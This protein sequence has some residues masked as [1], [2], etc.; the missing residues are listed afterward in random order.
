MVVGGVSHGRAER[1]I[2]LL[3][4]WTQ[5][6]GLL[7]LAVRWS[8]EPRGRSA[9]GRPRGGRRRAGEEEPQAENFAGVVGMV[10][11][12][13]LGAHTGAPRH[14]ARSRR[15]PQGGHRERPG[16][17]PPGQPLAG[18]RGDP[19]GNSANAVRLLT[20]DPLVAA[21]PLVSNDLGYHV[22]G[23]V[24]P[25]RPVPRNWRSGR[26]RR[27]SRS[28]GWTPVRPCSPG[29]RRIPRPARR[30]LRAVD[31]GCPATG[32]NPAPLLFAAAAEDSG[33]VLAERGSVSPAIEHLDAAFDT[34]AAHDATADARRSAGC[35]GG[36]VRRVGLAWN[37]P[38]LA[39][40]ASR[41]PN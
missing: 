8:A 26:P 3:T 10:A 15:C 11:L 12:C 32:G 37:G 6:G 30:R 22:W 34:Y 1:D 41:D 21:M 7:S 14:S 9:V 18:R 27:P 38:G 16:G 2:L 19:A 4:A 24:P 13:Q 39:G 25:A 23:R 5:F 35:C 40:P 31:G 29:S 36:T 20:D 33:R 28:S 17:A